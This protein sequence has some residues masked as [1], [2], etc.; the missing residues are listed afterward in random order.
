M[1]NCNILITSIIMKTYVLK[2]GNSLGIRLPKT[3]AKL[4]GVDQG[5]EIEMVVRKDK[6]TIQKKTDNLDNLLSQI[7][8]ANIHKETDWGTPLGKEIW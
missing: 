5:D 8:P 7:T 6:M 2:W 3:L 1:Y 4:L